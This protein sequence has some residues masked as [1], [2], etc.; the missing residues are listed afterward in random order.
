MTSPDPARAGLTARDPAV[1]GAYLSSLNDRGVS[2]ARIAQ[3]I[4][5]HV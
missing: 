1:D 3:L 2:F 5:E 4:R